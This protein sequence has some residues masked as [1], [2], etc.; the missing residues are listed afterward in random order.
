ML[1][2]AYIDQLMALME[3]H[4]VD[5]FASNDCTIKRTNRP[6]QTEPVFNPAEVIAKHTSP[7]PEEPWMAISDEQLTGF[8]ITGKV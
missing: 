6:K 2:I 5:E 3:K 1:D 7:L 8:S 4:G